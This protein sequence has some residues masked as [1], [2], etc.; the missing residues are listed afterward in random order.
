MRFYLARTTKSYWLI[1]TTAPLEQLWQK[2][3][4]DERTTMEELM[5]TK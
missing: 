4:S 3:R 2:K 5:V 1:G